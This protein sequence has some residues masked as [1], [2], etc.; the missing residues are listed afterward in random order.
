[1]RRRNMISGGL[2]RREFLEAGALAGLAL[3]LGVAGC[4]TSPGTTGTAV[5]RFL[6][7]VASGDPLE[8]R[9]ILW[10]RVEPEASDRSNEV[11]WTIARD[12]ALLDEVAHGTATAEAASDFT[13]KV[14]APGLEPANSYYYAFAVRGERSPIGRTRTLPDHRVERVRL[15]AC[16]CA[17]YAHGYYN[18]YAALARRADL[19]AVLHLG[20]YIYEYGR[21]GYG[22]SPI[23]RDV[24]PAYEIVTL[25]DYRSRYAFYRRDPDLQELHRQ[26]PMIAVWDDHESANNAWRGGAQNHDPATEGDWNSRRHAALRAWREWLPVRVTQIDFDEHPR[27][28]RGFRFGALADLAMLDTRLAARDSQVS[29][30][31][32]RG[33]DAPDRSLLGAEQER[34]LFERLAAARTD[35]V[36]WSLVAQQIV[37][38]PWAR[39]PRPLNVDA[40]DGYPAARQRVLDALERRRI[41]DVVFLS[42]D[43][44]S[45]WALDVPRDP[46]V[47]GYDPGTGRGSLAVEFVVPA[48]AS[49]PL[50]SFPNAN[51]RYGR[52]LAELPHLH[53][54]DLENHGYVLIDVTP[55]T[56][57][58]DWWFVDGVAKRRAGESHAASF[59]VRRGTNHLERTVAPRPDRLGAP[60]LA[61]A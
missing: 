38:A 58:A 17:N 59:L 31:D 9:V 47:H 42:G 28:W 34:W 7:G 24:Q 40:W 21:E 37:F 35:D 10:T 2:T 20:D 32:L 1:M 48:I 5:S 55:E 27:A 3:G 6:H 23:G 43:V 53:W 54:F 14:D 15:A 25:D 16:S 49:S 52:S 51:D 60:L 39:P 44:H 29:F 56:I 26:H 57:Q 11:H 22:A 19:D 46:F 4:R 41:R 50:A 33:Y 18:A 13:V 8:D 45:S 12:S 61:P 30:E 36:A